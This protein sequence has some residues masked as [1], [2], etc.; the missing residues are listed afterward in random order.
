MGAG[1]AGGSSDPSIPTLGAVVAPC[2]KTFLRWFV[3]FLLL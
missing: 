2:M 3:V 1:S